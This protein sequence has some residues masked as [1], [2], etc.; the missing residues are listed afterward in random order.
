MVK[1]LQEAVDDIEVRFLVILTKAE[2]ELSDR[3][4]FQLEQAWWFYED[5]LRY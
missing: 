4:F 1:N 5:F 2:I 3:L